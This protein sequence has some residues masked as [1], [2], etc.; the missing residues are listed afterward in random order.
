MQKILSLQLTLLRGEQIEHFNKVKVTLDSSM[1]EEMKRVSF[2]VNVHHERWDYL[3]KNYKC[4]PN[5]KTVTVLTTEKLFDENYG[6]RFD[7]GERYRMSVYSQIKQNEMYVD[8]GIDDYEIMDFQIGYNNII[9]FKWNWNSLEYIRVR[10]SLEKITGKSTDTYK[11]TCKPC[12]ED[13]AEI[14]WENR[15]Y[16]D[17]I[18]KSLEMPDE[19]LEELME[20]NSM[21]E[22]M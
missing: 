21:E 17:F 11:A 16:K 9:K 4:N 5:T 14:K 3:L 6:K 2:I 10:Y 19:V 22:M 7:D 20:L 13:M 15:N 12:S 18:P 1:Y 8:E